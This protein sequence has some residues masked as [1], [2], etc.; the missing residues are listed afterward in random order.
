[1]KYAGMPMGMWVLFKKSFQ[2][3]LSAVFG[4]DDDTA[5]DITKRAKP[6]YKK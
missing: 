1:M 3:Q 2:N 6:E 5:S 4:Y